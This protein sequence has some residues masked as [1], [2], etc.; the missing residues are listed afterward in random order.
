MKEE[1][2]YDA[3]DAGLDKLDEKYNEMMVK[4]CFDYY[5]PKLHVWGLFH[6]CGNHF[7]QVFKKSFSYFLRLN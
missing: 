3:V 1:E 4:S 5:I 6:V 7:V 2:F